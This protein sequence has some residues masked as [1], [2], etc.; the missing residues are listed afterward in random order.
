MFSL[1]YCLTE[2][3]LSDLIVEIL[4]YGTL[5]YLCKFVC[6]SL[7][8]YFTLRKY[9]VPWSQNSSEMTDRN[10]E[11]IRRRILFFFAYHNIDCNFRKRQSLMLKVHRR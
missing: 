11:F 5:I 9:P 7:E 1:Q 3:M 6:N 2:F 10:D 8:T 4:L